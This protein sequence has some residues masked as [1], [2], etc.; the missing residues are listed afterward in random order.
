MRTMVPGPWQGSRARAM[1]SVTKSQTNAARN[2]AKSA[3]EPA[4]HHATSGHDARAKPAFR[5]ACSQVMM[6][7]QPGT[8]G[9]AGEDR[10]A[11]RDVCTCGLL[12][13]SA[14]RLW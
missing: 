2:G 10:L 5:A 14:E 1:D 3:H 8:S 11:S 4:L 9:R 13:D 7:D 6:G 12:L